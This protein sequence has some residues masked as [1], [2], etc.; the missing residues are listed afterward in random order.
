[1]SKLANQYGK[2]LFEAA[3]ADN[4]EKELKNELDKISSASGKKDSGDVLI[5]LINENL[6][7]S[8][9]DVYK[10][11]S[12]KYNEHHGTVD[13]EIVSAF[14]LQELERSHIIS[15]MEQI[16]GKK[17]NAIEQVDASLIGGVVLK[18]DG[19]EIDGSVK[20]QLSNIRKNIV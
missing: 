7:G 18:F 14:A 3:Y 16:T 15:K 17:V 12:E 4:S 20:T 1:M 5:Q 11:F 2:A 13:V 10:G 6:M 9:E 8:F 19:N